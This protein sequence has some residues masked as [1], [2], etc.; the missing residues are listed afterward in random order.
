M[1]EAIFLPG[2]TISSKHVGGSSGKFCSCCELP[3]SKYHSKDHIE[4]FA[5]AV[6]CLVRSII[7]KY[8]SDKTSPARLGPHQLLQPRGIW[9]IP[10]VDQLPR[11]KTKQTQVCVGEFRCFYSP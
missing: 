11:P 3:C 10:K 8:T 2:A 6:N 5:L 1:F 9:H 4:N 7:Q